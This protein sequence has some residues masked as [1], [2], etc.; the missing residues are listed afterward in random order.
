MKFEC[1]AVKDFYVLYKEDELSKEVKAAVEEHLKECVGCCEVYKGE[2]GFKDILEAADEVAPSKK[3]DQKIM[4]RLKIQRLRLA[5]FF[6]VTV[7]VIIFS[8][9]YSNNRRHLFNDFS[10]LEY[11][12]WQI[13]LRIDIGMQEKPD[14]T[15]L[16]YLVQSV[17]DKGS[18]IYRNLNYFEKQNLEKSEGRFFIGF[19]LVSLLDNLHFKQKSVGLSERDEDFLQRMEE[20]LINA[21]VLL[22]EQRNNRIMPL[23]LWQA[24]I[25]DLAD[26]F[27]EID[28]LILTYSRHNKFPKELT[29]ASDEDLKEKLVFLLDAETIEFYNQAFGHVYFYIKTK[30]GASYN[31]KLDAYT[32]D[33]TSIMGRATHSGN[34]LPKEQVKENLTLFLNKLFDEPSRYEIHYKGINYR[35]RSNVDTQL[36]TWEVY[37][38]ASGLKPDNALT[39]RYDAR[40]GLL[41]SIHPDRGSMFR[42]SE[43][44]EV[45]ARV[46]FDKEEAL[47]GIDIPDVD[48]KDL[49]YQDTVLIKSLLTGKMQ[50]A[51]LYEYN[52]YRYYVNAVLGKLDRPLN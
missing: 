22:T 5:V 2:T 46:I 17:D 33:I 15:S 4:L 24:N 23:V 20:H 6:L 39:F 3:L 44:E 43:L 40:T 51:H 27:Y 9:N 47:E 35:Y 28:Q 34:L 1:A 48:K 13:R 45:D 52:H 36:Y 49:V 26:I 7:F 14:F 10:A 11:D 50:A 42:V 29:L 30:D 41:E 19:G 37:P 18:I 21:V 16:Q 12:L 32:G 8:Q 31:G 38:M 25:I